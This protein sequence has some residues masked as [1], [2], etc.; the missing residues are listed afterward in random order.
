MEAAMEGAAIDRRSVSI[1]QR[2]DAFNRTRIPELVER[3]YE[4]MASDAFVFFRGTAHLFWEDW[5]SA[6]HGLDDAPL[7]WSC[8]DL[9]LENFGSYRGDNG[10]AYFDLNDFDDAAL[11]P[12]TRDPARLLT[13]MHLAARS[14]H[15]EREAI[16]ELGAAY[17]DAYFAAL[18]DGTARWVERA[19]ARGMVRDLLLAVKARTQRALLEART[20]IEDGQRRLRLIAGRTFDVPKKEHNHVTSLIRVYADGTSE[21][22]FY[23]VVDVVG[24]IAGTGSLGLRRY[25]VLVRGAGGARGHRLLDLKQSCRSAVA[26]FASRTLAAV[27]PA[28]RTE[29]DR[30]V[31]VQHRMQAVAPARLAAVSGAGEQYVLRELQPTEDRLALEDWNGRLNRLGRV[32]STMGRLTAWAQLRS[33]SRDGAAGGDELIAFGRDKR[34]RR[35]LLR[36]AVEYAAQ[37]EKDWREFKVSD[38]AK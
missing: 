25:A 19:T 15:L 22:D 24:R 17:L 11:A 13:S 35:A 37:V 26:Q 3:K 28:W 21:P 7:A 30:V 10:L 20:T 34:I 14:L 32:A 29:G 1:R 8:G 5:P 12:A 27:Q 23:R 31:H 18:V 4:K 16:A 36:F 33:R 6:A 9:H 38:N 2:I